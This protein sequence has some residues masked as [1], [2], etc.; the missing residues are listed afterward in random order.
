MADKL[1]EWADRAYRAEDGTALRR[2]TKDGLKANTVGELRAALAV[3]P[4]D[5]RT[6]ETMP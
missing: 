4:H 3:L 6:A 5:Q 2:V 1:R